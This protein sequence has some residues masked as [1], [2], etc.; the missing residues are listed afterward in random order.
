[1]FLSNASLFYSSINFPPGLVPQMRMYS[2][3]EF[4]IYFPKTMYGTCVS[5]KDLVTPPLSRA[6]S[7]T[8]FIRAQHGVRVPKKSRL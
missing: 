5:V 8:D 2:S 3:H 1:M 6:V 7:K 4:D